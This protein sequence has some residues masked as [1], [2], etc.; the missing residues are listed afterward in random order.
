MKRSIKYLSV[1]FLALFFLL[2]CTVTEDNNNPS[3]GESQENNND[4]NTNGNDNGNNNP[5]IITL[6]A[7]VVKDASGNEIGYALDASSEVIKVYTSKGFFAYLDWNGK[8]NNRGQILTTEANGQGIF[9]KIKSKIYDVKGN[10]VIYNSLDDKLYIAKD[11]D[12]NGFVI[13]DTVNNITEY[14]SEIGYG[15]I[16]NESGQVSIDRDIYLLTETTR[17]NIGLPDSITGPLT[18]IFK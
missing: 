15:K 16:Y 4:D 3:A 11:V 18:L 6:N 17:L 8:L 9:F 10:E 1:L 7:S 14:K 12:S 2:S 5:P 13:P